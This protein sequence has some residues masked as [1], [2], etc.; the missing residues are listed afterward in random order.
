MLAPLVSSIFITAAMALPIPVANLGAKLDRTRKEKLIAE[1]HLI[2][3]IKGEKTSQKKI[4]NLKKL[5]Q[6][7]IAE[8]R[9]LENRHE[10]LE[11]VILELMRRKTVLNE[12]VHA[13]QSRLRDY[14]KDLARADRSVRE[15]LNPLE[16]E[17][18]ESPRRRMVALLADRGVRDIESL[19]ADLMDAEQL[20]AKIQKEREE[21][22]SL[23]QDLDEQSQVMK[24]NEKAEAELLK[25]HQADSLVQLEQYQHLKQAESEV[26]G[27]IAQFNARRELEVIESADSFE[28][29]KGQLLLPVAGKMVASYGLSLDPLSQIKVFK[30]GI[31]IQSAPGAPVAAIYHGKV[32]FSGTL[33]RLG[34]VLIIDHGSHFFSL[35]GHLGS[36]VKR[37]GDTVKAGEILGHVNDAAQP[38]YFEI[39]ARNVPLNPLQW[40]RA[41]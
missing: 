26:E 23:V 28:K 32:A 8:K 11:H 10:E 3:S 12:K 40:V 18:F 20:D 21:L 7:Q 36:R 33:P 39:R 29:M 1:Q 5:V 17:R 13:R 14:L 41:S 27:L 19:K 35:C 9:L 2:D 4:A 25:R 30:K 37:E 15:V 22:A 16:K 31:E 38:V 34:E 24:L 6:L